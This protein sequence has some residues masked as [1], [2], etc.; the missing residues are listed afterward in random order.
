MVRWDASIADHTSV[1]GVEGNFV[2]LQQ[3]LNSDSDQM[4]LP[5][6]TREWYLAAYPHDV[7]IPDE[8]FAKAYFWL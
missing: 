3:T 8:H 2:K 4:S 1:E 6:I 7:I 5:K